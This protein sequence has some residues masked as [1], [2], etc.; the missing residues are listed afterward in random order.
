[1][2]TG[3]EGRELPRKLPKKLIAL[4]AVTSI[5]SFLGSLY[6]EGYEYP[7]LA[8]HPILVNLISGVVGFSTGILVIALGFNY[9]IERDADR[10][11]FAALADPLESLNHYLE[12]VTDSATRMIGDYSENNGRWSRYPGGSFVNW[13]DALRSG[14][15]IDFPHEPLDSSFYEEFFRDVA[16]VIE[17]WVPS[18]VDMLELDHDSALKET[19]RQAQGVISYERRLIADE[20][21][22]VYEQV[23]GWLDLLAKVLMPI[24]SAPRFR[25]YYKSRFDIQPPIP[26]RGKR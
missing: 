11:T 26:L 1:V 20:S 7:F 24:E 3:G 16:F 9:I 21:P 19:L 6:L 23:D 8:V 12:N 10:L 4:L 13:Y 5:F 18:I 17:R 2:S 14:Y 22:H 25:R 15:T